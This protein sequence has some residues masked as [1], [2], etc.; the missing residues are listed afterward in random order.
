MSPGLRIE[1]TS[2]GVVRLLL[3]RPPVNALSSELY[4]GLVEAINDLADR[5]DVSCTVLGSGLDD[6]FCAG[7]DLKEINDESDDLRHGQRRALLARRLF[8]T[9]FESPVPTIAVVTGQALGAGC[10]LATVCDIRVAAPP[11]NFRLPEIDVGL[12]GGAR[13]VLRLL[14]PGAA[15]YMSLTGRGLSA[16]DAHRLGMVEVLTEDVATAWEAADDIAQTIASKDPFATRLAKRAIVESE[17]LNLDSGYRV[18][19]SYTAQLR[20]SGTGAKLAHSWRDRRS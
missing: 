8:Q 19:Q 16:E 13:H 15:R 12:L 20:S 4:T 5:D 17:E 10:V 11:A 2:P 18:E 7:A 6:P 3:D 9:I 14:P 1:E